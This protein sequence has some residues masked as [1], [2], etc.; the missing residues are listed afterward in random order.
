MNWKDAVSRFQDYLFLERGLSEN[1]LHAY[2]HDVNLLKNYLDEKSF[3]LITPQDI[4][5][6]A[7]TIYE[8][9]FSAFSQARIFSGIRSFF[10]FLI[11]ENILANSPAE[12]LDSPKLIRKLPDTLTFEE[13]ERILSVI[14]LSSK[15]GHRNR[16]IVEILYSCGLRVSEL[17]ELKINSL[18]WDI[19]FVKIYG[20][21]KKERLVP[22]GKD[23]M[24]YLKLYL[25]NFRLMQ[26][27]QKGAEG[28]VFLNYLGGKLSRVTIF[29]IIKNLVNQAGIKK[30]VSPH[31]FRHS[32]ATHMVENGA[33]LRIVQQ[34][35]GHESIT[36]TEIYT[37]LD[38]EHLAK[39]VENCHPRMKFSK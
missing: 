34:L 13:I 6:F 33:D 20:K 29:K 5:S 11:Q 28:Y 31:T 24:H 26:K 23:A 12:F 25:E 27:T 32:Y 21:G 19:G 15:E 2:I 17:V 10:N 22:I 1:T 16:A 14:D 8:L 37:H 30:H 18:Y 36:T 38:K 9:G 7:A 4:E 35:L 3:T 39:I